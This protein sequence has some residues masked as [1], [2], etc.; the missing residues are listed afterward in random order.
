M[1]IDT[2][3]QLTAWCVCGGGGGGGGCKDGRGEIH[4]MTSLLHNASTIFNYDTVMQPPPPPPKKKGKG[5]W[6][7]AGEERKKETKRIKERRLFPFMT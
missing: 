6:V 3:S 7:G 2:L 4:T 1:R 5:V